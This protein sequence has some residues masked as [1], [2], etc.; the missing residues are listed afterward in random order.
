MAGGFK[1]LLQKIGAVPPEL[2]SKIAD[3]QKGRVMIDGNVTSDEP[4]TSPI[5]KVPC[6]AYQYNAGCR[7]STP[8]GF[9]RLKLR[10]ARVW[11]PT[12]HLKV[13]DG[14]VELSPPES[15]AFDASEHD[16]LLTK[17]YDDFKAKEW[18]AKLGKRVRV[19]GK[20]RKVGDGWIID[21]I[22]FLEA[23]KPAKEPADARAD[24]EQK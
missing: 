2:V 4:L 15:T 13:E 3:L 1:G 17:E 6:V 19:L 8:K 14:V 10:R 16:V 24:A 7:I 18:P 5:A 22:E 12:M 21:V 20:A 9:A 23:D 11:A